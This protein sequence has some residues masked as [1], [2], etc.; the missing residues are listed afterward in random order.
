MI[1]KPYT[2]LTR[3]IKFLKPSG[4]E[5][6]ID[7]DFLLSIIF[8]T[9][10]ASLIYG[11]VVLTFI[12]VDIIPVAVPTL[13]VLF[14]GVSLIFLRLGNLRF[15]TYLFMGGMWLTLTVISLFLFSNIT[16]PTIG[17]YVLIIILV[18]LTL[19]V[20]P[21]FLFLG[22]TLMVVVYIYIGNELNILPEP[23]VSLSPLRTLLV[24]TI[25]LILTA[26]L[27]RRAVRD[28]NKSNANAIQRA[29]ELEAFITSM[30]ETVAERTYE[31][32][33]QK[34]FFETLFNNIP[35]AVVSVDPN[36]NVVACNQSFEELFL[37]KQSEIV[38][39]PLDP[40]VA[41]KETMPEAERYSQ[42]TQ[43]GNPIKTIT[44]RKRKDGS[45]VGV[46]LFSVPIQIKGR[47]VGA[48]AIYRDITE[49]MI[50]EEILK[51]N[52][53]RFRSLFEDSP[54]SLWEED[55]SDLKGYLEELRKTGI[56]DFRNYFDAHPDAVIASAKKIKVLNVNQAT[57]SL[58][59]AESKEELLT[60]ISI[61]LGASS[62]DAFKD[63]LVSLAEGN[64]DFA[65]E[66]HQ[67]KLDGE[68]IIGD[69]RLSIA[70]GYEDTWEKVYVSI[71]DITERKVLEE[72]L[73]ESLA[74]SEI[75]ASTDPLT[76][77][78]NRRAI[79]E[80]AT[81]ELARAA[82]EGTV[83]GIAMIDM[84]SL[85]DVNDRY[86]H[87]VGDSALQLFGKTLQK[88][89]RI[90][91]KVGRWGGDEFLVVIPQMDY[92]DALK[93]AER[94]KEAV[95][96]TRLPLP[97]GGEMWLGACIGITCSTIGNEN[98]ATVD[99]LLAIADKALYQAKSQ[100][101]NQFVF[102]HSYQIDG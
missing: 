47:H 93:T 18:G 65:C 91:D 61:I 9:V 87:P 67:K 69:L 77:L 19:G 29:L 58:F 48:L 41:T 33:E 53:A 80:A 83:L 17:L 23:S 31:I 64:L 99:K 25:N 35:I 28:I 94:L 16:S 44:K 11:G 15:A 92:K 45:Q 71:I 75:L 54:I 98:N 6:D 86:G 84:D 21:A 52:E 2:W 8:L 76:H 90:Y 32:T 66:I 26:V 70:P 5:V 50:A 79:T 62:M 40:L 59:K 68:T 72:R 55:F 24:H 78:L 51:A 27:I 30:E 12:G 88:A 13:V 49:E 56:R 81:S 37:Y 14:G 97:D 4:Q 101:R 7:T 63:E 100:G 96:K 57:V 42:Q 85:K 10:T 39:Q 38:G 46:E 3:I 73:K 82:R 74:K 20:R 43:A 36:T 102:L 34:T 1:I 89:T 95:N 60:D 22:L